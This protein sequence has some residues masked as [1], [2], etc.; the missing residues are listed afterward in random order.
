MWKLDFLKRHLNSKSHTESVIKLRSKNPDCR[1]VLV[2][3][4]LESPAEKEKKKII[5]ER[6]RST[7]EE[8]KVLIDCVLLAVRMNISM[9]SV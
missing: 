4:F 8:I 7:S 9:L 3:M 6:K 5:E 1:G 2:N